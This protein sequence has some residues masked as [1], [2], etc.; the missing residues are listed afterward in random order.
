MKQTDAGEITEDKYRRGRGERRGLAPRALSKKKRLERREV[1]LESS[2]RHPCP[3][4]LVS[5]KREGELGEGI[6]WVFTIVRK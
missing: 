5:E 6:G 1:G 2:K 4:R 3:R